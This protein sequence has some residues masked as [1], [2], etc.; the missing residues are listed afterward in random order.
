MQFNELAAQRIPRPQYSA[1]VLG[2]VRVGARVDI[3]DTGH[4]ADQGR[5]ERPDCLASAKDVI[6]KFEK[7]KD[8]DARRLD[9]VMGE[10]LFNRHRNGRRVL[11]AA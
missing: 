7:W 11:P 3:V 4:V 6:S 5:P 8:G 10:L 2:L 1:G 9:P